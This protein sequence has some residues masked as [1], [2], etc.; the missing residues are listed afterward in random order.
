MI[1]T[2]ARIGYWRL[3]R[4]RL[5]L[6]LTFVVPVLFFSIF[7]LIFDRQIGDRSSPQMEIALSGDG[8]RPLYQRIRTLLDA[9]AGLVI[10]S[11]AVDAEE[12]PFVS[13]ARARELIRQGEIQA[14]VVFVEPEQA[15]QDEQEPL[16]IELLADTS[17]PVATQ[18]LRGYVMQAAIQ[19]QAEEASAPALR[20]LPPP[21]S[22]GPQPPAATPPESSASYVVPPAA[23]PTPERPEA[24]PTTTDSAE[25]FAPPLPLQLQLVDVLGERKAN[26]VVSMYAAG[27]A[28]MFLL[29]SATGGGGSLLEE[30]ESQTLERLLATRLSMGQLL[31][32]KWLYLTLVGATQVAV[33]FL[34]AQWAFRVDLWGHL[35][36]FSAMTLVTAAAAASFALLLATACHSRTQLNAVSII[37]VLTMSALGG[38]MVPRYVMSDQMQRLGLLTFNGWALDGY[39]KVFWRDLPVQALA[40]Q[41]AVLGGSGM[42]FLLAARLLAR[43]WETE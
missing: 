39:L 4:G 21:V 40:P 16:S 30:R 37:L 24:Q 29:F 26:P 5:E 33:M 13:V 27:I 34:W 7:A 20:R 28:V 42:L 11:S 41:L 12:D 38:S 36:G 18:V 3:K 15:A 10:Y 8:N 14:A 25:S 35:S 31:L 23:T 1:T 19:A 9:Q 43:R 2:V 32:G 6:L 22:R 17:D